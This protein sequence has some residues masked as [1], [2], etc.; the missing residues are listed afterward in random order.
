[1]ARKFSLE[2]LKISEKSRKYLK[3]LKISRK[4]EIC[5]M[6]CKILMMKSFQNALH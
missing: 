6:R 3:N 5:K 4:S 2:N 1:M